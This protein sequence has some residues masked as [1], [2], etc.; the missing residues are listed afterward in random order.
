M[1]LRWRSLGAALLVVSTGCG[2]PVQDSPRAVRQEAVTLPTSDAT[3][4][5]TRLELVTLWFVKD[6]DLI[7]AR[8]RLPVPVDI[9]IVVAALAAGVSVNE[10]ERSLR[11][12]IPAPSMIDGAS[13]AGGTA[14]VRL[15]S[16]FLDI[17]VADQSLA[18]AQIVV[19]V[20][21]LRGVGRVR[22][23]IA[24]S[25]VLVPL[26]DGSSTDDSVSRDLFLDF[27]VR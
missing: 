19:T 13:L 23:V 1:R 6:G 8:R 16:E 25:P 12:A 22:F 4:S 18:V 9:D 24:D 26:P 2:F 10:V 21:D 14:T 17:P 3:G 7:P 11:S 15:T 27:L 5:T 20:T